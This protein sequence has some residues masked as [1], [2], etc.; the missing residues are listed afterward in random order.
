MKRVRI[1]GEK[2]FLRPLERGDLAE[3]Y[4]DDALVQ[5][6]RFGFNQFGLNRNQSIA[7][8][9]NGLSMGS[10][11]KV[12]MT[13]E[14]IPR[15]FFSVGGRFLNGVQLAILPADFDRIHGTPEDRI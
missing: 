15:E 10:N 3:N 6:L 12:G 2:V 7:V 14:G 1:V 9:E 5:L 13:R 8:V 11:D 4:L